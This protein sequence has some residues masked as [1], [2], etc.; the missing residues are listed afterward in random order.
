MILKQ[1]KKIR[2]VSMPFSSDVYLQ[3]KQKLGMTTA[4]WIT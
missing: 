4:P 3:Q 2:L 1:K